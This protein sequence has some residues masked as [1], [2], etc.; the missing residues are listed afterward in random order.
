MMMRYLILFSIFVF[1]SA[2]S[3]KIKKE[4]KQYITEENCNSSFAKEIEAA[5][6]SIEKIILSYKLFSCY[7]HEALNFLLKNHPQQT[8]AIEEL[9]KRQI[10]P[11]IEVDKEIWIYESLLAYADHSSDI[12]KILLKLIELKTKSNQP[13]QVELNQIWDKFP[14]HNI[15]NFETPDLILIKDLKRRGL[16]EKA[17]ELL[18]ALIK[19]TNEI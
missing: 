15:K 1:L 18:L 8:W 17:K 12:E 4:N 14:S 11:K 9:V 5:D 19:K 3:S 10:I 7:P 13:Y 16:N 6:G 2:F